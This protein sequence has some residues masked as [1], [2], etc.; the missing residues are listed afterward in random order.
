MTNFDKTL[1][2]R[3][4][5]SRTVKEKRKDTLLKIEDLKRQ[6]EELKE[7]AKAES[8]ERWAL[9]REKGGLKDALK[10]K[11]FDD[12]S[13]SFRVMFSRIGGK[14][15]GLKRNFRSF[16]IVLIMEELAKS[17]NIIKKLSLENFKFLFEEIF[18]QSPTKSSIVN[19][20]HIVNPEKQTVRL[21][22]NGQN[23]E[24]AVFSLIDENTIQDIRNNYIIWLGDDFMTKK[25]F[26]KLT[27]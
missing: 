18:F 1:I 3:V 17:N 12:N 7:V 2:N 9:I 19:L 21:T 27:S 5:E 11:E 6:L 23:N 25:I 16:I 13:K 26:D 20:Q 24:D 4:I 22:E 10:D 14:I 8:A 15:G